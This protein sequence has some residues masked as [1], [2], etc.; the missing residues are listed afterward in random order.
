M[1]RVERRESVFFD[2]ARG[3]ENGFGV[4]TDLDESA[5]VGDYSPGANNR[6]FSRIDKKAPCR[7][8]S[9]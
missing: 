5:R 7:H 6:E 2:V 9:R 3:R 1:E 4:A 8:R